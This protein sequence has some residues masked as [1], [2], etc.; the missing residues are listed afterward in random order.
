MFTIPAMADPMIHKHDIELLGGPGVDVRH[1]GSAAKI[2]SLRPTFSK[3]RHCETEGSTTTQKT[4]LIYR[5]GKQSADDASKLLC[6]TND[7][8]ISSGKLDCEPG[9]VG[10]CFSKD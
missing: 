2:I 1:E 9:S 4:V 7:I 6:H 3:T 8:V 10:T 5:N